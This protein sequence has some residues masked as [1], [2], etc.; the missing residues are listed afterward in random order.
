MDGPCKVAIDIGGT[1]VVLGSYTLLT[2]ICI[3]AEEFL[4]FSIEATL[5]RESTLQVKEATVG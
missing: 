4:F 3:L 1:L 2:C 5:E